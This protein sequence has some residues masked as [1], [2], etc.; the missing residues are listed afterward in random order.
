MTQPARAA[1]YFFA[2]L[3][4][5]TACGGDDDDAT[6]GELA[7]LQAAAVVRLVTADNGFGPGTSPFELVNVSA[8]I[9][10]DPEQPLEPGA[11][12]SIN[13][14]L[15]DSAEVTFV[16]DAESTIE[17]LFS[18]NAT[19]VAVTTIQDLRIDNGQ[20]ELDMNLWCGSLCGVIL[21]YE[22]QLSDSG[23]EILGTV[24][25]IAMS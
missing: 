24:G 12:D 20:A 18:Q 11:K 3:L 17:D 25:P 7:G 23:W 4:F 22:A 1:C 2:L 8:F 10:D 5:F 19:E 13:T 21:T 6:D 14:A 9:D 15:R 16:N